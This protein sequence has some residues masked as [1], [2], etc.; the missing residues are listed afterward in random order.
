[1]SAPRLAL[2]KGDGYGQ[3]QRVRGCR[4]QAHDDGVLHLGRAYEN[5]NP[6]DGRHRFLD[7][8]ESLADKCII[9]GD[10]SPGDVSARP[11]D[12]LDG[13][14]GD[15]I[16]QPDRDDGNRARDIAHS[17]QT[18]LRRSD[19]HVRLE[20]DQLGGQ[21][22]HTF[23]HALGESQRE[24]HVAALEIAKLAQ[25]RP[26]TLDV[27]GCCTCRQWRQNPDERAAV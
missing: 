19:D 5:A 27:P 25:P 20:T 7:Q 22:W 12:A 11:R 13:T 24:G 4:Q 15:W 18:R 1:M 26:E 23:G 17:E 3:S 9:S 10:P 21:R 8:F 6:R 16:L 14:A 2:K